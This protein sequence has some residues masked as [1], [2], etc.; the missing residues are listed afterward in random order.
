MRPLPLGRYVVGEF[1]PDGKHLAHA[2]P[3]IRAWLE[4]HGIDPSETYKVRLF[5]RFAV[6]Y[7]YRMRDGQFYVYPGTTEVARRLPK[8]ILWRN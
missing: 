4:S 5:R 6:V 2:D 3:R 7:R 1:S 8:V